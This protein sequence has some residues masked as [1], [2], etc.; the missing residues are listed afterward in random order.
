MTSEIILMNKEAIAMAA[1]SAATLTDSKI[2]QANK[3][4]TLSKYAP[5]GVMIYGSS[6]FMGIPWETI[7]KE[8]RK[9]LSKQKFDSI[10]EYAN[11]F[12]KFLV[13]DNQMLSKDDQKHFFA[14][15]LDGYFSYITDQIKEKVKKHLETNHKIS[16]EEVIDIASNVIKTHVDMWE[17]A[18]YHL[19]QDANSIE[20]FIAL[21][22]D[23]INKIFE[24][25]FEKLS[26]IFKDD[27]KIQETYNNVFKIAACYFLKHSKELNFLLCRKPQR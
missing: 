12:L 10:E 2:F 5:V 26:L 25:K 9:I 4:F 14:M 15:Y 21:H 16:N 11:H 8:Y 1:D 6:Q 19:N 13:N 23:E 20:K 3:I 18:I 24:S 22:R 7:I 17:N 27:Q